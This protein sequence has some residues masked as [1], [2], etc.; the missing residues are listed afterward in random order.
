M[1]GWAL[2]SF[3]ALGSCATYYAATLDHRYGAADPARY[4][5][6]APAAGAGYAQVKAILD[7]RC[8]VCHGCNDAPCQLN[9]ASYQGLTRGANREQVYATR[10][11][12]A[13]PTRLFFDAQSSAAWRAKNFH[14]VLNER[15]ATPEAE[16]EAGVLYRLLRLKREH[17]LAA[18]A[19]LPK[20]R[21][22]F[23]IDRAQQCPAIEALDEHERKYP[24]WG[25]PFGLPALSQAEHDTLARWIEA[26]APPS[27]VAPLPPAY[28]QRVARWE[29]FLNGDSLKAR[30]ASR[31]IFEHWFIAH[32][33]F[34]DL[35]GEEYFDLVRSKTPPG[36]PIEVIATRRPY[37]HPGVERAYYRLRRVVETPLA[38]THM[39]YALNDARMARLK[40]WFLDAPYEVTVLPSH[41]P[42]VASNPFIA[43]QQL[44]VQ[45]RYRLMLEESQ[46]TLMGFIKGPVCRGQVAVDVINDHFWVMFEKPDPGRAR[47]EAAFLAREQV[48]LRLPAEE[49]GGAGPLKWARYASLEGAYLKAKG[50]ALREFA[51]SPTLDA[52]WDGDGRNPNAALTVLRHFDSASVVQG[53]LGEQPQTVMLIGYP[54]LERIHYLLV[55]GFDVYGNAGHQ[56]TTRLYMDFLRMEGEMNFFALLP[57]AERQAV[58]DRWYRGADRESIRQLQSAQAYFPYESG[59]RYASADPLAELYALMKRRAAPV[60]SARYA[61]ASSG[62]AA[63]PQREL[64]RLAALRGRALSH[65]PETAVLTVRDAAGRDHHFSLIANRAHSNVAELFGEA[66]RRLPDEDSLLVANGFIPAYP[67]AFFLVDIS[68]LREFVDAIARLDSESGYSALMEAYGIRRTDAR[69]WAHSDALHLAWRRS[70]PREAGLFDYNRFENR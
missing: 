42:G 70:A 17:P 39:P 57:V 11:L 54:L 50:E 9:L 26:G 49:E 21:F 25:M 41:D 2:L 32:L 13:E 10:L 53:L 60:A 37:D 24:D 64:S 19:V 59:I 30:L 1:R 18:G 34:D 36:Q 62:L 20:E 29:A 40:E 43:F 46:F 66:D 33:Y 7:N 6:A 16:R 63:A 45:A 44:P 52:L 56:L 8:A 58:R 61:L 3:L 12:T 38:K 14:P 23:S 4:D 48:N 69:F 31:Y 47:L 67:N 51:A 22:D 28:A 65:L 5:R 35:P 68:K 55:A 15:A 27:A